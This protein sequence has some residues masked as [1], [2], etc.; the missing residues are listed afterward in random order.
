MALAPY[1]EKET[2]RRRRGILIVCSCTR[3]VE[4]S[5]QSQAVLAI[6][7]AFNQVGTQKS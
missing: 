2:A 5:P 7:H 4:S 3:F 6:I 1:E